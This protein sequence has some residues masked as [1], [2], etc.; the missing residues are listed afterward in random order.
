MVP[1]AY[2][3]DEVIWRGRMIAFASNLR[4]LL[5]E[6]GFWVSAM[7][8]AYP[9]SKWWEPAPLVVGGL[10][11]VRMLLGYFDEQQ[12]P[13]RVS[14]DIDRYVQQAYP[15]SQPGPKARRFFSLWR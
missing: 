1:G 9:A 8:L 15:A 5:F 7:Y 10:V 13:K 12:G 4:G 3:P 2:F 6:L 14:K 11:C